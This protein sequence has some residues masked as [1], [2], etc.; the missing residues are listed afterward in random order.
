MRL[1]KCLECLAP[2]KLDFC[3][4]RWIQAIEVGRGK[5]RGKFANG[6]AAFREGIRTS[7]KVNSARER[8]CRPRRFLVG[9]TRDSRDKPVN[10]VFEWSRVDS[11]NSGHSG[12]ANHFSAPDFYS[13]QY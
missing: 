7:K 5:K 13:W 3:R 8:L 1:R 12:Q 11:R 6:T 4:A 9:T 2:K 10:I